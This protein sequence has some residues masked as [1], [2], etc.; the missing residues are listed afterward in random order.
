MHSGAC[1]WA[2]FLFLNWSPTWFV[3]VT[4]SLKYASSPTSICLQIHSD[5]II[6]SPSKLK[7]LYAAKLEFQCT[8]NIAEYEAI[9]LGLTKLNDI[10]FKR[11]ILKYDSQ[12]I[13][14]H[15]DKSR[16]VKTQHWKVHWHCPKDG[17]IIWSLLDKNIP[18]VDN[19]HVDML[20][21]SVAQ[22]LPLPPE[23]LFKILRA[24]SIDLIERTMLE[25]LETH[26]KH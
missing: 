21:K 20:A 8:N 25:I 16:R 22:R 18:R 7:T 12:V 13:M 17:S 11:A 14:G 4:R 9:L 19:E 24:P 23:V 15:V 1:V 6:I 2:T 26:N 3:N 10:C 5:T